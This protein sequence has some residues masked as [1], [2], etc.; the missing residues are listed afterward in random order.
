MEGLREPRCMAVPAADQGRWE[1]EVVKLHLEGCLAD[2]SV[3]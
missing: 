3:V 1:E 2:G